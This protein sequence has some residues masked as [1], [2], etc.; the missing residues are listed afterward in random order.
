MRLTSGVGAVL[1]VLALPHVYYIA[2]ALVDLWGSPSPRPDVIMFLDY[3]VFAVFRWAFVASQG[4]LLFAVTTW[5]MPH[6]S[7]TLRAVVFAVAI[8]A[9]VVYGIVAFLRMRGFGLDAF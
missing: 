1:A 7:R 5:R 8:Q 3:E 2:R 6:T 9:M 4:W